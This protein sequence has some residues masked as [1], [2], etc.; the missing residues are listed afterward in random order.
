MVHELV[1]TK[2]ASDEKVVELKEATAKD[3]TAIATASH[4]R[5][6][7][8]PQTILVVMQESLFCKWLGCTCI[9]LLHSLNQTQCLTGRSS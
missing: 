2:P 3:K 1:A 4:K 5:G 8:R 9:N 7:A 6:M